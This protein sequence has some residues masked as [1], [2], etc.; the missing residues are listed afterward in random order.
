MAIGWGTG[1]YFPVS[2]VRQAIGWQGDGSTSF[3]D[4]LKVIRNQGVPAT[5]Q[6]FRSVQNIRDVIDSGSIAIILFRIEGVRSTRADPGADLFGRYYND[7]G[8]HYVVIK[9]YSLNEE[10]FVIHDPIPSDWNYNSFRHGDETSMVGRNRY[11]S[12]AELLR[13]L[14]RADMIV[15]P[16]RS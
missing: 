15:V 6:P 7:T 13:A 14:R 16:G 1:S 2:S 11:Y 9:G 8:G 5:I 4:L 10:Y 12:A 3:E